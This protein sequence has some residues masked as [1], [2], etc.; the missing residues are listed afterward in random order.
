MKAFSSLNQGGMCGPFSSVSVCMRFKG[1]GDEKFEG[2][3]VVQD[4]AGRTVDYFQGFDSKMTHWS[5]LSLGIPDRA[6]L[7]SFKSGLSI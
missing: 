1:M 5:D 7:E 6:I 3:L 2:I 4:P